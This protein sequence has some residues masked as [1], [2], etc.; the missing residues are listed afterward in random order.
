MPIL[1]IS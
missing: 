1:S